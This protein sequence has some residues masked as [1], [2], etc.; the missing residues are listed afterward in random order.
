MGL[1][2]GRV[3]DRDQ[4]RQLNIRPSCVQRNWC[5]SCRCGEKKN[6]KGVKETNTTKEKVSKAKKTVAQVKCSGAGDI[7]EPC[8]F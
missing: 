4:N 8:A 5:F 3:S 2:Q 1:T 6:N 7:H